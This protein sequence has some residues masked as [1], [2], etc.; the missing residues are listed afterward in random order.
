[1]ITKLRRRFIFAAVGVV[2]FVIMAIIGGINLANYINMVKSSDEII[3]FLA[4]TN[5]QIQLPTI[6]RPS[7]NPSTSQDSITAGN[8]Y[9]SRYFIVEIDGSGDIISVDCTHIVSLTD[10]RATQL[11]NMIIS[12]NDEGFWGM[13]RYKMLEKSDGGKVYYFLDILRELDSFQTFATY[14]IIFSIIGLVS[15]T[16]FIIFVSRVIFKPVQESYEKQKRFITDAGHELNTPLSIISA[17]AEILSMDVGD[18]EWIDGI[19][20]QVAKLT[21]LTKNLVF[22]AKMEESE[23]KFA[24]D[25]IDLS[26]IAAEAL[27]PFLTVCEKVGKKINLKIEQDI[28]IDGN[29][30]MMCRMITLLMDNAFKHSSG[31]IIDF[32]LVKDGKKTVLTVK[33]DCEE[34][35]QGDLSVL[36]E[37]F[38]RP[39]KSR[40]KDAGGSGIGLSVVQ[41]I[42]EAHK[43]KAYANSPD[44]KSIIFKIVI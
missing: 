26:T 5:T 18:S 29:E 13:Y 24:F 39:A 17:N 42:A 7:R 25:R 35:E 28:F 37:R 38:Y 31:E 23:G 12:R 2:A 33:N 40:G 11:A 22:V 43:G 34:I 32:S 14:S 30:D 9:T 27:N 21:R 3:Q 15:I 8:A 19:E 4:S 20:N 1:M 41:S 16:V 6:E 44:G 36:F 10:E